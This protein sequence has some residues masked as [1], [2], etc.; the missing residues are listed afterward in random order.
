[1]FTLNFFSG[2]S[3]EVGLEV[4]YLAPD[5]QPGVGQP[6]SRKNHV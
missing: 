3:R 6:P 2:K 1:V 5:P 4:K